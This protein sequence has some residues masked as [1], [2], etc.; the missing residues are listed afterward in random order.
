M[1]VLVVDDSRTA[2][3]VIRSFFE[4][5]PEFEVIGTAAN[6]KEAVEMAAA[7]RPDLVTLDLMLPD[8]DGLEVAGRIM[9]GSPT[10]IMVVSRVL[11]RDGLHSGE[12]ALAAGA[13]DAMH[14]GPLITVESQAPM[15]ETLLAKARRLCRIRP[16]AHP[17]GGRPFQ[18]GKL[19]PRPVRLVV[20]ASSTGGPP[21]VKDIL[22]HLA[23]DFPAP[24]VVVQH[25][26]PGVEQGVAEWLAEGSRLEVKVAAMGDKLRPGL[27]LLA[28]PGHQLTVTPSGV[29]C[30]NG[31]QPGKVHCPSADV[32]LLAAAAHY[33]C[34]LV[35]VMLSGLGGDGTQG[36]AAV[37]VEGGAT[38]AQDPDSCAAPGMPRSAIAAGVVDGVL[39][40]EQI[41][42]TLTAICQPPLEAD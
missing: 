26:T 2:R 31:N 35:A 42:P 19:S 5:A 38:I 17:G 23:P 3:E 18:Q 12:R 41:A 28:P 8:M 36:L 25:M 24:V 32:T 33:R 16:I 22:G 15:K 6:G 13:L 39:P 1:R 14:K 30:L 34:A 40:P 11:D 27:V 7:L 20:I 4:C 37:R 10:R 29:I 9:S 21:V